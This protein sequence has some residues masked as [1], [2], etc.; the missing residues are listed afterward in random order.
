MNEVIR[1]N[2]G[3]RYIP[4][5]DGCIHDIN[6]AVAALRNQLSESHP[7]GELTFTLTLTTRMD[8]AG[9]VLTVPKLKL[10]FY[11]FQTYEGWINAE[12][13]EWDE[14]KTEFL[15]KLKRDVSLK[16]LAKSVEQ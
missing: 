1:S 14:V 6:K 11:H 15:R 10:S 16:R 5:V 12:G 2:E 3:I 7:N 4:L 9:P 8:V 13:L